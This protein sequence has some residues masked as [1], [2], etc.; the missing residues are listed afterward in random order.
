MASISTTVCDGC[1]P[2]STAGLNLCASVGHLWARL[3]GFV[4]VTVSTWA[5][6]WS[7]LPIDVDAVVNAVDPDGL[8]GVVDAIEQE[9]GAAAGAVLAG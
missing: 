3:R 4:T 1:S 5:R 9:V 6:R 7:S 8:F 2:H